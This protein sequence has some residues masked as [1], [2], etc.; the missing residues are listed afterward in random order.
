MIFFSF[1][2]WEGETISSSFA[3]KNNKTFFASF[4]AQNHSENFGKVLAN[5]LSLNHKSGLT[6]VKRFVIPVRD[7]PGFFPKKLHEEVS[8]SSP[9]FVGERSS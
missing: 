9:R 3:E 4:K 6:F 7:R 1:H 5:V 2:F 8:S